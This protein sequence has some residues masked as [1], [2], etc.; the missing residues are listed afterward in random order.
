MK[1]IKLF[2]EFKL[3]DWEIVSASPYEIEDAIVAELMN[4]TSADVEYIKN[5]FEY[6]G[7]DVNTM[8]K[9]K[10]TFLYWASFQNNAEIV[11]MLLE[12]GADPNKI[13]DSIRI[14]LDAAVQYGYED[15]AK[16]LLD[17][18][19][20]PNTV[21]DW[22]DTLLHICAEKGKSKLVKILLKAG[23]NPNVRNSTGKTPLHLA[24]LGNSVTIVKYL[25]EAGAETDVLDQNL[26][27]PLHYAAGHN[28]YKVV[29]I[30][31]EAGAD[32]EVEGKNFWN[33]VDLAYSNKHKETIKE[34]DRFFGH[35]TEGYLGSCVE[36]GD[37]ESEC[38]ITKLFSDAT[39][40]AY[41]VGNPDEGDEGRS[42]EIFEDEFFE[43]IK[44]ELV[45]KKYLKGDVTFHYIPD[46]DV[47]F[48]YNEDQDMHYFYER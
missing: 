12:K 11:K 34:F 27:T 39:Q 32:Y 37:E 43:N 42:I 36:V 1:Y 45:H 46:L 14:P 33:P 47:Y 16:L 17:N 26:Q 15:I 10:Y 44:K 28:Y 35:V 21:D 19:A 5:L 3:Q 40:M 23:A 7:I 9:G 29:R 24:A 41:Y 22:G 30:L 20:N 31:L 4:K 2:E 13:T 38:F 48:I 6:S 25:L 18:G 8:V